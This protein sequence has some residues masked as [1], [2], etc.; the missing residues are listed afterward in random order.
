MKMKYLNAFLCFALSLISSL[1]ARELS[2]WFSKQLEIE[3]RSSCLYQAYPAVQ[4][5]SQSHSSKDIFLTFGTESSIDSSLFSFFGFP[6]IGEISGEIELIFA[7]T[8]HRPFGFDSAQATLRNLWLNDGIGDPVSLSTGLTIIQA[9]QRSLHDPS[10]F[11]H[12]KFEAEFHLAV[13]KEHICF[14]TWTT[15]WW[16]IG[17]L[18]TADAGSPWLRAN[19]AFEWLTQDQRQIFRVFMDTL[20]GFGQNNFHY[21]KFHG[22]GPV[23][24]QSVDLGIRYTYDFDI[25]GL[26]G[27][28]Y[29]YRV[30]AKNFPMETSR[31]LATYTFPLGF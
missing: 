28:E 19:A 26:L 14:S 11:H 7:D 18:G 3:L 12:G 22:Y 27:L 23:R 24:H 2:P 4:S 1:S 6:D 13:G 20:W 5:P 25:W 16:G 30:Y 10:S 8:H 9:C 29:S 31:L 15:R 21:K 17:A